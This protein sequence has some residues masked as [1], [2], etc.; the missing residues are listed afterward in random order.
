MMQRRAISSMGFRL[1]ATYVAYRG[2]T[3]VIGRYIHPVLQ[4]TWIGES[5]LYTRLAGIVLYILLN[6]ILVM[7]LR[8]RESKSPKMCRYTV[9]ELVK[10]FAITYFACGVAD[11]LS[12]TLVKGVSGIMGQA[13]LLS[14]FPVQTTDMG[15]LLYTVFLTPVMEERVFRKT[16]C[17]GLLP[18][19]KLPAAVI[20]GIS[21]GLFHENLEQSAYASA[22]GIIFA[23]VY[24]KT[25]KARYAILLHMMIN[26]FGTIE[27]L[28]L[29][30]GTA[31]LALVL[32]IA[33]KVCGLVLV[34]IRIKKKGSHLLS[35][36]IWGLKETRIIFT[37]GILAF[38]AVTFAG[39]FLPDI[40]L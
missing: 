39:M 1:V 22:A 17:D 24:L 31:N 38:L 13:S 30:A 25:G 35:G 20:S 37:P 8:K 16:L 26:G 15:M 36:M 11:I 19:G 32:S 28:L 10:T 14:V 40:N 23:L 18:Y 27:T 12:G 9:K 29:A 33:L 34:L 4:H 2:M 6:A 7:L 3:A 21:F 5:Q